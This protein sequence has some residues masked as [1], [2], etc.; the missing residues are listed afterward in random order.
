MFLPQGTHTAMQDE[1]RVL[2]AKH[3]PKPPSGRTPGKTGCH[4]SPGTTGKAGTG[5][6]PSTEEELGQDVGQ[7][8]GKAV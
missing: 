4:P 2:A 1:P 3:P 8:Y 7:S 5:T 6:G